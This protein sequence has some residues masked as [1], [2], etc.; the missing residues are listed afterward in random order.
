MGPES[1]AFLEN[2]QHCVSLPSAIRMLLY[3]MPQDVAESCLPVE[4]NEL[5]FAYGIVEDQRC[6]LT[7]QRRLVSVVIVAPSLDCIDRFSNQWI[8][9]PAKLAGVDVTSIFQAERA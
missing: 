3:R 5:K 2:E 7:N 6:Q 1:G 9:S 8:Q 4:T